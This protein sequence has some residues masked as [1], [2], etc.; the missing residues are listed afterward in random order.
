MVPQCSISLEALV[1]VRSIGWS[2]LNQSAE[3]FWSINA[4]VVLGGLELTEEA[5]SAVAPLNIE[6]E[7]PMG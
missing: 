3:L 2:S 4:E 6:K 7:I 5:L 1:V